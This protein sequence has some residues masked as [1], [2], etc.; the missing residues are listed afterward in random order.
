[1]LITIHLARVREMTQYTLYPA[2][3]MIVT[4]L[5]AL[6]WQ[7]R[8]FYRAASAGPEK[9]LVVGVL[10]QY[11]AIANALD[12]VFVFVGVALFVLGLIMAAR[13]Y[14]A[15]S[16]AMRGQIPQPQPAAGDD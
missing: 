4:T 13:T 6:L 10:K 3:F 15:Y 12:W 11:G 14:M 2:T 1:M 5:A 7:I 9:T 8:V 16:Q